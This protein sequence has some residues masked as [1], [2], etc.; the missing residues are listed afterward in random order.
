MGRETGSTQRKPTTIPICSPQIP[1]DFTWNRNQISVIDCQRLTA[2]VMFFKF[3]L[4]LSQNV[5]V[6]ISNI[7]YLMACTEKVVVV[8]PVNH[9]K[10]KH[11]VGKN[12]EFLNIKAGGTYTYIYNQYICLR[13]VP[14]CKFYILMVDK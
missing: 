7:S 2:C 8:F 1:Y 5:D 6:S 10:Q 3:T 14:E 9:M 12:A 11:S 13:F 4:Y